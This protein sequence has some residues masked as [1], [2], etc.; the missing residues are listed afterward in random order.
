MHKQY[1]EKREKRKNTCDV[2]HWKSG[3]R[4]GGG[5]AGNCW[6]QP[7]RH[8]RDYGRAAVPQVREMTLSASC[9]EVMMS[10]MLVTSPT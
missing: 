4:E 5:G 2:C 10:S 8:S 9:I 1:K 3:V 6:P 7:L